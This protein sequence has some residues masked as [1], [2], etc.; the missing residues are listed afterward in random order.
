MGAAVTKKG[1]L[2]FFK[3]KTRWMLRAGSLTQL[4]RENHV[5]CCSHQLLQTAVGHILTDTLL[6]IIV[7]ACFSLS[8]TN[9]HFLFVFCLSFPPKRRLPL[10][11]LSSPTLSLLFPPRSKLASIVHQKSVKRIFAKILVENFFWMTNTSLQFQ[12]PT[13][14]GGGGA[15]L[16]SEDGA[17][18]P[19]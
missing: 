12:P 4:F 6:S 9:E 8:T 10:S 13:P 14:T 17:P 5:G 19:P 7:S 1:L 3:R 16:G 18:A 2:T 15:V 11:A